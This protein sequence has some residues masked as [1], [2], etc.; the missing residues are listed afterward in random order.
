[1]RVGCVS[2]LLALL[3]TILAQPDVDHRFS[4]CRHDA[5]ENRPF[6]NRRLAP[7]RY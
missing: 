3:A 1:M 4:I 5:A 6:F 7:Q 2:A